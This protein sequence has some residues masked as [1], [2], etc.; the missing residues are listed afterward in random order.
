MSTTKTS[1]TITLTGYCPSCQHKTSH[2]RTTFRGHNWLYKCDRCAGSAYR[3]D[4]GRQKI[5]PLS[6]AD[7]P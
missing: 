1:A 6:I 7:E 4:S 3:P 5:L 2:T